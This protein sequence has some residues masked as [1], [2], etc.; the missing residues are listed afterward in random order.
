MKKHKSIP[1][2]WENEENGLGGKRI[3]MSFLVSQ[4]VVENRQEKERMSL[5]L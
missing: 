3:W 4:I 5:S 1:A 2:Q